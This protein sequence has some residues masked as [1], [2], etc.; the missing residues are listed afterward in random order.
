MKECLDI[1]YSGEMEQI[2]TTIPLADIPK[3]MWDNKDIFEGFLLMTF[4]AL[5]QSR[6]P[7][8]L[9]VEKP[10]LFKISTCVYSE[11]FN[12]PIFLEEQEGKFYYNQDKL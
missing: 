2:Q 6:K 1:I 3:V 4:S 12:Y 11:S 10:L 9:T 7:F 8:D 5:V